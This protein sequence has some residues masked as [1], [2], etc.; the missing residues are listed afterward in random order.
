MVNEGGK[1]ERD[2]SDTWLT[3]IARLTPI[4]NMTFNF[5]YSFRNYHQEYLD[6]QRALP[7][8]N[9]DGDL[10]QYATGTYPDY[11]QRNYNSINHY[12]FDA[13]ADYENTFSEKHYFKAMM[14]F[15]QE[16]RQNGNFDARRNNLIVSTIPYYSLATENGR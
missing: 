8:Y 11:V 3:G 4:R 15:N 5:D 1:R 12:V 6:H 9:R 2:V 10:T 14:G 7:V 13:F 16:L